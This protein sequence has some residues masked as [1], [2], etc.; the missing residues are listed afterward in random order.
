VPRPYGQ[1]DYGQP[2][3]EQTGY[4]QTG[5]GQPGY[6]QPGYG[7]A[8]YGQPGYGPPAY[9]QPGYP[10]G[11]YPPPAGPGGYPV[12]GGPGGPPPKSNAA[13]NTIIAVVVAVLLV[14]GGLGAFFGLK[15]DKK[16]AVA[17]NS[18]PAPSGSQGGFPTQSAPGTPSFSG[19][20]PSTGSPG[21]GRYTA[22]SDADARATVRSYLQA[23]TDQDQTEAAPLIC[24]GYASDWTSQEA[25]A[26]T[27]GI[28][29]INFTY[30]GTKQDSSGGAELDYKLAF[31]DSTGTAQ[32]A[33]VAFLLVD[34][35]GAKICGISS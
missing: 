1:P 30:L 25:G 20:N 8:A 6:G 24:S 12:P 15:S 22:P 31:D 21:N 5:Y 19:T 33:N 10:Q 13:R 32:T 35:N 26:F 3:Y 23:V 7:Q 29:H 28:T 27:A 4:E 34:E 17:Q 14:G 18:S 9:G 11:G 2:G 16:V